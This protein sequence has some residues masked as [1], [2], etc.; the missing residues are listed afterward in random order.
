MVKPFSPGQ[1]EEISNLISSVFHEFIGFEYTEEGN[2]IFN[3]FISP[4]NILERYKNG[5]T[6]LTFQQ[7]GSI[8][9][10]IE[11]RDNKHIS[12]FFVGKKHH[13][14]GIGRALLNEIVSLSKGK[15]DILT[16]N[17]SPFSEK[18]YSKIGFERSGEKTEKNG[19]I[20]IPMKMA[21]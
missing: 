1:E 2:K 8:I 16:V 3:D 4:E 15:T 6:I 17:A 12:L 9:G 13:N 11:V 5:N 20:F 10:I 18:I 21:L 14:N 19:I 7:D